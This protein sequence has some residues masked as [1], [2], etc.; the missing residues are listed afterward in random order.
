MTGYIFE[1][2][3]DDGL[4]YLFRSAY[5]ENIASALS[6]VAYGFCKGVVV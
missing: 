6:L 2:H 1:D 4:S 5:P 3:E